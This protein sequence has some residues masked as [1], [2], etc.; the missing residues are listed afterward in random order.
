MKM[1]TFTILSL[2]FVSY[3]TVSP[4]PAQTHNEVI[5]S[6]RKAMSTGDAQ[7]LAPVLND[8][9]EINFD[10]EK[11]SYSRAQAEFILKDFFRKYPVSD[12]RYIHQGS[13]RQGMQY[14][15]GKYTYPEGTFR[16]YILVKDHG[17]RSSIDMLDFG[18]E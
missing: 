8:K 2:L 12:F 7:A 3:F 11:S 13:S 9:V 14:A 4:L 6:V 17:G 16:V 18:K 15:I 10:E 5:A 1:L